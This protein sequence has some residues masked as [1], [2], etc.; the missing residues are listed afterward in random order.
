MT[1]GYLYIYLNINNNLK[2][3]LSHLIISIL[4]GIKWTKHLVF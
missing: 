1:I 2:E 4:I 3:V